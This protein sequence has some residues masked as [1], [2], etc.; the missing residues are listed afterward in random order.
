MVAT[1]AV[2]VTWRTPGVI[3][4]SVRDAAGILDVRWSRLAGWS[5]SGCPDEHRCHHV[6]AV[7]QLTDRG[8]LANV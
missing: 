3:A 5:C 6:A 2:L 7:R 8:D 1:A 4:A